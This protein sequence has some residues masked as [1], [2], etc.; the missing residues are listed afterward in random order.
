[1]TKSIYI[2]TPIF[3]VNDAPHIGH[4]YTSIIADIIARFYRL[5]GYEVKFLTGTDEHGQKVAKSAEAAGVTPQALTDKVS[6]NFRALGP[7]LNLSNDIFIRTT[8]P[9]HYKSAQAFWQQLKASE[10]IYLGEYAGW[11]ATRDEAFY[12]EDEI[13][14]GKAPTGAP[15][16]WVTESS[17]FFRLSHFQEPLLKFYRDNPDFIAPESRRNEVIRFVEGGLQDLS[18]SR[19]TF[20]WGIPVPDAP[21][22]IMYVWLDALTNYIT[23]LGYPD[24]MGDFQTYWP[25]ALHLV[26]KDILRFHA[27]YWPAF[28]MAAGLPL[29][30]RIFAHGWWTNEGQKIS[31]S[32]GNAIDPVSLVEHYGVDQVRYF[33]AREVPFGHDGDFSR[34]A[35]RQR[36]NSDLANDIG[37][38]VQRVCSFLYKQSNGVIPT[39]GAMTTED[40]H[41]HQ[42]ALEALPHLRQHI[43]SQAIH[44]ACEYIWSIVSA[45]NRYVDTQKP[46]A[47]RTENPERLATVLYTLLEVIR[48]LGIYVQPFMP[49]AAGKLLD[50]LRVPPTARDF[51][52]I[53]Q[54]LKPGVD[55]PEP[56]GLFPRCTDEVS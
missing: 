3:Y 29:P 49:T 37:N 32:L 9:R 14:D 47:L 11:Y 36:I 41:L 17:Y 50:Q 55:L 40:Q 52:S 7:L 56:Q 46:W 33:M 43:A 48:C 4:A 24:T 54:P 45:A 26:G 8:E 34:A 1:M 35:M 31:K 12:S 53:T 10:H 6:E 13:V 16:E 27:V 2:T 21:G 42:L 44:K 22:H 25:H 23:A 39:P 20:N 51:A 18:I 5:D 38:L 15:V 19:T 30:R 28:L